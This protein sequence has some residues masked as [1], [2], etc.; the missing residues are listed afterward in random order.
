MNLLIPFSSGLDSTY[1]T[2]K[3]LKKGDNVILLYFEI[4]NNN[5][6]TRIE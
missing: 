2:W 1:L 5:I 4:Q 3:T 6:K